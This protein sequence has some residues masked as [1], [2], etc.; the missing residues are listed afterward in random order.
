MSTIHQPAPAR[1]HAEP[2]PADLD[3]MPL[4]ALC[5]HVELRYHRSL[6]RE[7]PQLSGLIARVERLHSIDD[8]RLD[9]ARNVFERLR[10]ELEAHMVKEERL[11]FPLC[12][13]LELG[14][15]TL[16]LQA[17]LTMLEREHAEAL[18]ALARLR[19]LT[20]GFAVE[21]VRCDAHRRLMLGLAALADETIAH[22]EVEQRL[23]FPRALALAGR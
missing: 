21:G 14:R 13:E 23:L 12:L 8:H 15:R 7:L 18:A 16:P 22:L 3:A 2:A 6:R 4:R 9:E 1:E 17:A 5:R 10:A 20:D 19:Q 11:V